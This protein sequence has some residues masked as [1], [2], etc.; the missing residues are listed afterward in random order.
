VKKLLLFLF[1]TLIITWW[2]QRSPESESQKIQ[3][4]AQKISR[5]A[6]QQEIKKIS[7]QQPTPAPK[8]ATISRPENS[9]KS[10]APTKKIKR[11]DKGFQPIKKRKNSHWQLPTGELVLTSVENDGEFLIGHGDLIVGD[12]KD[13][14]SYESGKR[15]L[16]LRPPEVWENRTIP[17]LIE[18]N[19]PNQPAIMDA[20]EYFQK[21]TPIKFV[22][23][24]DQKDYVLF[25]RGETLCLSNVGKVGGEQY[26][27]LAQD[28]GKT[29]IIHELMH[30]LGFIHEQNRADRDEYITVLW[31]NIAEENWPQFQ[32]IEDK[33]LDL[34]HFP[35][36]FN[37]IML[38][39]SNAFILYPDDYSIIT[40]QGD[41]I[42]QK[43]G[44]LLSVGDMNRVNYFYQ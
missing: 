24:T 31:E 14:P 39:P 25:K 9:K 17:Y 29:Q 27:K 32:I 2:W 22:Q 44:A 40:I 37:S 16:L 11:I 15:A 5:E 7:H 18:A 10:P 34:T 28:C 12:S 33:F 43:P 26:I 23:R 1:F 6:P 4:T 38:Y 3:E 35:F 19:L 20:I 36:D 41:P 30:T 21:F 8:V 42:F 13:L